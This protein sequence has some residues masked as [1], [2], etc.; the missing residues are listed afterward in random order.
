[1][2]RQEQ[3]PL[4]ERQGSVSITVQ[5]QVHSFFSFF[6]ALKQ[7]PSLVAKRKLK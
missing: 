6:K 3:T 2:H 5:P 4:S 7:K 1:M